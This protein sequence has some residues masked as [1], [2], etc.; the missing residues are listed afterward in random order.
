[1]QLSL[2]ARPPHAQTSTEAPPG[3]MMRSVCAFLGAL[4]AVFALSTA[5]ALADA[6]KV[7]V[8]TGTGRDT[9]RGQRRHGHRHQGAR[10]RQ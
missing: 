2:A 7:L 6:G 9:Q 1:M 10:H 5:P 4:L 3:R 8:F